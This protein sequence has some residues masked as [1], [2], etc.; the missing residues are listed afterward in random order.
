MPT[1]KETNMEYFAKAISEAKN[2]LDKNQEWV[3]RYKEYAEKIISNC[4]NVK[5][6]KK[7]FNQWA[8]LYLY[9]N[10]G[11][12][13]KAGNSAIFN[14]RYRGQNIADLVVGKQ[15]KIKT[16][17]YQNERDFGCKTKLDDEWKSER[18]SEFRKHFK[19]NPVRN[20]P[21]TNKGNEEHRIESMFLTEFSKSDATIKNNKLHWIQPVKI[22]N[23]ARFQMPTPFA[24]SGNS[25][26]YAGKNGGGIDIL[27]RVGNGP[28]TNLC[29]MEVKDEY[30]SDEPPTEAL[31]QGLNYA[32]F[33][34][35]LIRS[36]SGKCWWKIFGFQR[37]IPKDLIINVAC[38]MPFNKAGESEKIIYDTLRLGGDV[39]KL[40]Y[41]YFEEDKNSIRT[42][43][44][45]FLPTVQKAT[46]DNR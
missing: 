23:I 19:N 22:A 14:L 36:S 3:K 21:R 10:I 32:T 26:T 1:K 9:M 34:R 39:F 25:L 45:S 15:V 28:H 42:V 37:E 20:E 30:S 43:E 38:V 12:A 16:K 33:I 31:A 17:S 2:L 44:T 35:E 8:P 46:Y 24:A 13:Q 7:Q 11:T 40:E 4:G 5:A 6:K 29:V 18:A 41:I 27:A